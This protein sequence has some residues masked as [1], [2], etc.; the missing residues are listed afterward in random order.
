MGDINVV[1]LKKKLGRK[2]FDIIKS[3]LGFG[4][5]H[6]QCP[7]PFPEHKDTRPSATWYKDSNMIFCHV[8]DKGYD[9][10]EH[11]QTHRGLNFMDS[12]DFILSE[13]GLSGD[14]IDNDMYDI[15]FNR[16]ISNV[17]EMY[18]IFENRGIGRDTIS[19]FDFY[20]TDN[21]ISVIFKDVNNK[22]VAVLSDNGEVKGDTRS[23][24]NI[25]NINTD[26][27]LYIT[28]G[29]YDMLTLYD[30]GFTNIVMPVNQDTEFLNTYLNIFEESEGVVLIHPES[31]DNRLIDTFLKRIDSTNVYLAP[32]DKYKSI[33][34][35]RVREGDEAVREAISNP[36]LRDI[37]GLRKLE[38]VKVNRSQRQKPLRFGTKGGA[39]S[40]IDYNLDGMREGNLTVIVGRQNEGKTTLVQQFMANVIEQGNAVFSYSS[41]S[42]AEE[43]KRKFYQKMTGGSKK[44]SEDIVMNIRPLSYPTVEAETALGKWHRDKLITWE[45]SDLVSGGH[46][47]ILDL[48]YLSYKRYNT[49]VYIIDNLMAL[50]ETS[51]ESKYADQSNIVQKLKNFAKKYKVH[52]ILLVHP[53]KGAGIE[54]IIDTLEISGD[55]DISNK[56]D[57]IISLSRIKKPEN[58]GTDEDPDYENKYDGYTY[59]FKNKISLLLSITKNRGLGEFFTYFF[60][61]IKD[62]N[63][64]DELYLGGELNDIEM[65]KQNKYSWK[66]Y[67]NEEEEF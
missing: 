26:E 51:A 49:R 7:C 1:E 3:D 28:F 27:E 38:D 50:L 65:Y 43:F 30:L 63:M 59:P 56:P 11:L 61:F 25:E 6:N 12:T 20:Y 34:E 33:N 48:M 22:D 40:G 29:I 35:F 54:G 16:S 21:V 64:F 23:L 13:L 62:K 39:F 52:V 66:K 24:L 18:D 19:K 14:V 60:T 4:D 31:M 67:L 10:Y 15:E 5:T 36:K 46:N 47:G 44:Y 37:P 58:T 41:E 53:T 57:N 9:I 8:C 42:T 2:A 55:N 32:F 45:E 17:K